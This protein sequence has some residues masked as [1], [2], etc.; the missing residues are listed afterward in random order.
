MQKS[1]IYWF[2]PE[3]GKIRIWLV[4][5]ANFFPHQIKHDNSEGTPAYSIL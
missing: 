3:K 1:F 5:K 4:A 2:S